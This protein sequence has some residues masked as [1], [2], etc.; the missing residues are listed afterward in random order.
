MRYLA[1]LFTILVLTL[2]VGC[3]ADPNQTPSSPT[4]RPSASSVKVPTP[5]PTASVSVSVDDTP[6]TPELTV[7]SVKPA[8]VRNYKDLNWALTRNDLKGCM[9]FYTMPYVEDGKSLSEPEVEEL[10][11]ELFLEMNSWDKEVK[12]TLRFSAKTKILKTTIKGE[13]VF[14]R[15]SSTLSARSLQTD[16]RLELTYQGT[17]IW[18]LVGGEW[19]LCGSKDNTEP[20]EKF[21]QGKRTKLR[22]HKHR[23]KRKLRTN[24]SQ[25]YNRNLPRYQP[26][27]RPLP[28]QQPYQR[29]Y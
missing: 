13:K 28:Y 5:T 23:A 24:Y 3:G 2:L 29:R 20:E 10:L 18:K 27:V 17:D 6:P 21:I 11:R 22:K 26:P 25:P 7:A 19:K 14:T 9:A 1:R 8:I 12:G 15:V 16:N 4:P